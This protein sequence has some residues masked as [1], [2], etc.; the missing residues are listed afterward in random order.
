MKQF[1]I[2]GLGNFGRFLATHLYE[3][4]HEVLVID[5]NPN[6]VQDI[7]DSVSQAVVADATDRRA[8]DALGIKKMDAVIVC[9]GTVLSDSILIALNLKDMGVSNI[10]AKAISD[11]HSRILFKLGISDVFFPERD[12]AISLSERLHN[13]NILEYLPFIEGYSIVELATPE[14]FVGQTLQELDLRNQYG[15]QVVA[16]RELVPDHLN[17]VPGADTVLK[18][19]DILILIGSNEALNQLKKKTR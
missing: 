12:Q 11:P 2:I 9:T 5:K 15:V 10:L 17:L 14:E 8:L 6:V 13:P 7:K 16:V 18:D 4:G 19:S 3:K 1:A